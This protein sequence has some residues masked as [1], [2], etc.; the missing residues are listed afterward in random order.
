MVMGPTKLHPHKVILNKPA[1]H[2]D[3]RVMV[4]MGSPQILLDMAKV[5]TAHLMARHRALDMVLNPHH[6]LTAH[7]QH[8]ALVRLHS[9][10]TDSSH[11]IPAILSSQLAPALEVMA[12]APKLPVMGNPKVVMASSQ[13]MPASSKAPMGSNLP[14]THLRATASRVN[15][16]AAA[17]VQEEVV[18]VVTGGYGQEQSSMSGSGSGGGYGSQDQGGYG[19]QQ[20]RNRGRGSGGGGGGGGY[21]RGGFDRS[22][23]RGGTRG[24]TRGGMGG[25]ERGGGFNK[26]GGPRDQGSR[27]DSASEQDNS[28][29]N[30]IFVQGLGENVTI[31]SVSEYFKQIGLIKMNK[32]TGQPM[33][34]LYTDR[35]TGKLKGEATVSFD[36]PPS[37][38][39][40]IDW[41]DEQTSTEEEGMAV[42][43]EAVVVEE[44]QW[45]V[46]DSVVVVVA[47]AATV[48]PVE[49]T[50]VVFL[51]AEVDSS[52]LE[53]GS[54]PIRHVRT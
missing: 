31:E 7:P 37:A 45:A 48:A 51:V 47:V 30:T 36:D 44:D 26:F 16:A 34:N 5:V 38:K 4:A 14:T 9:H 27:H 15:M 21:G 42:A 33:I 52:V 17:A 46:V 19:G 50:G 25:G 20:D 53:T 40:A 43:E 2:M 54:V 41:F 3:S 22:G 29:N 6:K 8:M 49:A 24:G 39:A 12:P 10:P 13:A 1:S 11:L 18:V 28:D 35:E 32:K 23:G